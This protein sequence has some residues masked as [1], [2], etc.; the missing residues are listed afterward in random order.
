MHLETSGRWLNWH[1]H[2]HIIC[3]YGGLTL[4]LAIWINVYPPANA[5]REYF[6]VKFVKLLRKA[7]KQGYFKT[8]YSG[9]KTFNKLIN[10]QYNRQWNFHRSDLIDRISATIQYASKYL[11]KPPISDNRILWFSCKTVCFKFTDPLTELTEKYF[12]SLQEFFTRLIRHV[13]SPYFHRTRNYGIFSSRSKKKLLKIAQDLKPAA[14]GVQIFLESPKTTFRERIK[15]KTGKDPLLCPKCHTEMELYQVLNRNQI[16][17]SITFEK[18]LETLRG[19]P[20]I[21]AEHP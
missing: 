15:D 1:P 5:I 17:A 13:P 16:P 8:K 7:Y 11:L 4:D 10:E 14:Y 12:L 18:L 19:P 3:T 6:K 20:Q 9:Y 2:L 21:A